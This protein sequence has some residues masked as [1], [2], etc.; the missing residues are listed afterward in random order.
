MK[1]NFSTTDFSNVS[2]E[3]FSKAALDR[4]IVRWYLMLYPSGRKGI[5]QGLE[6]EVERRRR[7]KEVAIEYFAPLYVEA[8]ERDGRIVNT[9]KPLFYNYL[10]VHASENELFRLK[11]FQEQYNFP[12]RVI[13]DN[14]SHFPYVSDR[15]MRDLQWIARSY[16]G[17]VPVYTGNSCWIEK[18]DRILITKGQFKGVEARVATRPDSSSSDIMVVIE[19]WMSVPLLNVKAG[20]YKVIGFN[21][22]NTDGKTV[23]SDVLLSRLHTALCHFLLGELTDADRELA[24]QVISNYEDCKSGSDITRRRMY[25]ALLSAYTIL[26]NE[27]KRRSLI[28]MTEMFLDNSPAG[29]S[30]ALLAVILYACTDSNLHYRQAHNLVDPYTK[31]KNP[32]KGWRTLI[33]RLA[34]YD[35]CLGH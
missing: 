31:E 19:G 2:D 17:T 22:E 18:G 13:S 21:N 23:V 9:E 35:K 28:S 1:K 8:V 24:E 34:E 5:A 32:K 10:F 11:H 14:G 12:R 20:E 25:A 27:D 6:R 29:L 15:T 30:T 4:D 26:G 16:A 33:Q 7:E 3:A